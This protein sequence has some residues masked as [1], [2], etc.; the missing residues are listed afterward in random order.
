MI[1]LGL[2]WVNAKYKSDYQLLFLATILID[3]ELIKLALALLVGS[4]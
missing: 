3:F 4:N 1:T 2:A